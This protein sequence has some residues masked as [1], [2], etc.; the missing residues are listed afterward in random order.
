LALGVLVVSIFAIWEV[1]A[2]GHGVQ[3][4]LLTL[5]LLDYLHAG[6]TLRVE[7]ELRSPVNV[8]WNQPFAYYD[9]H[10]RMLAFV[11]V[12]LTPARWIAQALVGL[13]FHRWLP[14]TEQLA[15]QLYG[16][17]SEG[18][19]EYVHQLPGIRNEPPRDEATVFHQ[20]L[21]RGHREQKIF[22][23]LLCAAAI[24]FG[25]ARLADLADLSALALALF[26]EALVYGAA[27]MAGSSALSHPDLLHVWLSR[28]RPELEREG[29]QMAQAQPEITRVLLHALLTG[30]LLL[31]IHVA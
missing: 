8:V 4:V 2:R 28:Q 27:L 10:N 18:P 23:L 15:E 12:W 13:V 24:S 14:T 3:R 6:L 20:S 7:P 16:E 25:V 22:A 11:F 31:W 9:D 30:A 29:Q 26:V 5:L 21:R 17:A 1:G 19:S